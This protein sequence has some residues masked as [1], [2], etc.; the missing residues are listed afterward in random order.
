MPKWPFYPLSTFKICDGNLRKL[1]GQEQGMRAYVDI[2]LLQVMSGLE[3][4]LLLPWLEYTY[5]IV[6][7]YTYVH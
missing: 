4:C 7:I 3:L 6:T 5:I 1:A 2:E